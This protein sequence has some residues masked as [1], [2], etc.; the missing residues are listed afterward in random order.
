[1]QYLGEEVLLVGLDTKAGDAAV[2]QTGTVRHLLD[3][4]DLGHQLLLLLLLTRLGRGRR[5]LHLVLLV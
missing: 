3:P 1:M 4:A 2:G 5:D